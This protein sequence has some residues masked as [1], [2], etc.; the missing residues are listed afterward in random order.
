MIERFSASVRDCSLRNPSLIALEYAAEIHEFMALSVG[1]V[2][3]SLAFIG[4]ILLLSCRVTR[5][6]IWGI[7]SANDLVV[8]VLLLFV[9]TMGTFNVVFMRYDVLHSIAPWIQGIV[10][11]TPQ[12]RTDAAGALDVQGAHIGRMTLEDSRHSHVWFTYGVC[13]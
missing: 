4:L 9:V 3:G 2:V 5:P 13:P 10:D 6:R 12:S 7:S 11:S 1:M 8:V